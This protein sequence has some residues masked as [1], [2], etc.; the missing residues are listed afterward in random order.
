MLKYSFSK[1]P[2]SFYATCHLCSDP[3]K[4]VFYGISGGGVHNDNSQSVPL[5]Y[6]SKFSLTTD[7]PYI[8]NDAT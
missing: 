4:I 8:G 7:P 2:M 1:I 6:L 3:T 5:G